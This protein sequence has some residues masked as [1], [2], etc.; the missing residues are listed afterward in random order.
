[1]YL[2]AGGG[3]NE[4]QTIAFAL[5]AHV[6]YCKCRKKNGDFMPKVKSLQAGDT[7][8]LAY[9]QAGVKQAHVCATIAAPPNPVMDAP[10]VESVD[11]S[12]VT[13]PQILYHSE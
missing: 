1:M 3:I 7:V 6:I 4:E 2:A 9:R 8:V 12:L 13:Y 5:D 11:D 10:A